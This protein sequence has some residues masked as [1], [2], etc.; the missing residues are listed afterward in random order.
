[1]RALL[2]AVWLA[3][4][5][6]TVTH[7]LRPHGLAVHSASSAAVVETAVAGGATLATLAGRTAFAGGA[8][9]ASLSAAP[10][11][12]SHTADS[13]RLAGKSWRRRISISTAH[14]A[15]ITK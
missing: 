5:A 13:M 8:R 7:A 9:R 1:M 3:A 10:R 11:R 12:C 6:V 2:W 14:A 15:A 4:A